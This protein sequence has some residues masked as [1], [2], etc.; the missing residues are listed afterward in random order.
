M[1]LVAVAPELL[2]PLNLVNTVLLLKRVS[3]CSKLLGSFMERL[4]VLTEA[5]WLP[6]NGEKSESLLISV[7][8]RSKH[9]AATT[10]KILNGESLLCA[11]DGDDI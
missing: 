9:P 5:A 8:V 11:V 7:K 4:I 2:V 10:A 6:S 3:T 1:M